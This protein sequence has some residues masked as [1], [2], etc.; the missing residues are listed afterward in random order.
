MICNLFV[1]KYIDEFRDKSLIRRLI[2]EIA[3]HSDRNYRF[4][5]VCGGHTMA[6][7]RYGIPTLLPEN[8]SLLS[9]PGCP[10]C[11][12]SKGF[13]DQAIAYSRMEGV[14]VTSYG[15]LLRV[16]G[17]SSS[18][19][20]ERAEGQ[21]IRIVYSLLDALHIA[22]QNPNKQVVFLGIGFE[23]TAP[24]TAVG[25]VEAER[26]DISNFQVLS[27]HKLMP[28]AME[29]IVEEG[30]QLDGY[31]CPGHVS[32]ITG[33]S[34][35]EHIPENYGLGCVIAGFEP[36][37]IL[38]SILM[39]IR[40]IDSQHPGVEIQYRRAVKPEGNVK[41]K[42]FMDE[43]FIER[44]DHWRGLGKIKDSGLGI[45]EAYADFDAA[46]KMPVEVPEVKE[47]N[48]CICGEILKGLKNPLD[49]GLF[50]ASCTPI[51]PI[52][53]CMVSSE[54]AC[55]AYYKYKRYKSI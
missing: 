31:L 32:T 37:D 22:K 53:A 54:G 52:G 39:L 14:T 27:A 7:Q 29:A 12:T 42:S 5:E 46:N 33:K 35:Y 24:A 6:I 51:D 11:V 16:P 34:I 15:D 2:D 49:C 41:A 1:L 8:I 47:D 50:G 18:L 20:K 23:T 21:D 40:Q 19:E 55:Q 38:Q 26:Q 4:M 36:T 25:I 30:V 13:V 28:P 10:V 44:D 9:G 3:Q 43:V 45:R 17:S 48:G